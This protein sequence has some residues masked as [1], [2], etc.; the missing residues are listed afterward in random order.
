MAERYNTTHNRLEHLRQL[1]KDAAA[2]KKSMSSKQ[3]KEYVNLRAAYDGFSDNFDLQKTLKV[4][5]YIQE[6]VQTESA[7]DTDLIRLQ[8][9]IEK[10][11]EFQD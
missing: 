8:I 2:G 1:K 10:I 11:H 4:I 5:K 3:H 7:T 6:L 9:L